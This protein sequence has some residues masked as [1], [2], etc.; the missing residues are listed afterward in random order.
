MYIS[1]SFGSAVLPVMLMPTSSTF[2]R[3]HPIH[4]PVQVDDR[5][6]KVVAGVPPGGGEADGA[7]EH[8]TVEAV[9][10]HGHLLCPGPHVLGQ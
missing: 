4:G 5:P 2:S 1:F 9:V 3:T 6:H 10:L 7:G 8:P